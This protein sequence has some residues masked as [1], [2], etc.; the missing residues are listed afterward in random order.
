M[1]ILEI[2]TN[3]IL[4]IAFTIGVI[5]LFG[6][7]IALCNKMFYA[8][9]GNYGRAVCYI[10]GAIGTPIHECAHALFC[11]IFGHKVTEIKLF[12]IN[13]ADGTLGYV[14]HSFNPKNIY[15]KI[16]NFFIGIAPIIVIS[17][18]LYLM[19]Y[20]LLP[21]FL[22]EL[23]NGVNVV[24]FVADF[25]GA[26]SSVLS[27]VPIF[28]LYAGTWQW[29]VF[30]IIGIF[31]SLHMTLSKADIKGA[32]SGLLFVILAFLI[33]NVILGLIGGN[34]LH[35]FTIGVLSF[36]SYLLCILVLSLVI[37]V[38][39]LLISYCFRFGKAKILKK[40]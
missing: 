22:L 2:L 5:V 39:A 16:G 17:A 34:V 18:I 15:H 1:I 30:L 29:W 4:Q 35:S 12:Q 7:L 9:F 23:S 21:E 31:L 28:F 38:I 8:N 27:S 3:F 25:G 37:S 36:A 13:A 14:N 11:V 20:L 19:A 10:T 6:F 26:L 32:L 40:R 33:V 24:D